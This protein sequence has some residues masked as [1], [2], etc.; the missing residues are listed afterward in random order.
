MKLTINQ[1]RSTRRYVQVM[2]TNGKYD[3][4]PETML[5]ELQATKRIAYLV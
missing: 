1:L 2:Y 5:K 3:F 4:V